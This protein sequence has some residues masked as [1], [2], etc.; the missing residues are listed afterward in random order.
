M[1]HWLQCTTCGRHIKGMDEHFEKHPDHQQVKRRSDPRRVNGLARWRRLPGAA[2]RRRRAGRVHANHHAGEEGRSEFE[3]V[4]QRQTGGCGADRP[5][6]V[7]LTARR[8]MLPGVVVS[9]VPA[10]ADREPEEL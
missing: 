9:A 1:K 4:A 10:I 2:R 6:T 3:L 7:A 8:L 5:R